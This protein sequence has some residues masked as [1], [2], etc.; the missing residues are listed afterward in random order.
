LRGPK[1]RPP[2]AKSYLPKKKK[3]GGPFDMA[4]T[5]ND[6]DSELGLPTAK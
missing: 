1:L 4:L 2:R 6:L 5:G 3:C